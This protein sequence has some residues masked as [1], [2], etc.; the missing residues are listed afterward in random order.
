[1]LHDSRSAVPELAKMPT[2]SFEEGKKIFAERVKA[3]FPAGTPVNDVI[4]Q[5]ENQGFSVSYKHGYA[6]YEKSGFP[7]N[8]VWHINWK[9]N[10]GKI[11]EINTNYGGVCL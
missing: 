4:T 7:C 6:N 8:F 5:L 11:T 1:M 2:N 3:L 9:E 10:M